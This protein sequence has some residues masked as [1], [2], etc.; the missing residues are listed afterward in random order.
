[1]TDE[2]DTCCREGDEGKMQAATHGAL[3]IPTGF[4]P[5]DYDV[6]EL[7]KFKRLSF[8][9]TGDVIEGHNETG[10]LCDGGIR[11]KSKRHPLGGEVHGTGFYIHWQRGPVD[12]EHE[13]GHVHV[14]G[15]FVEDVLDAVYRR[16]AFYQNSPFA[17]DA[18][19]GAMSHIE[20]A[21]NLLLSRREDRK[22]RGV[23]GKN[24]K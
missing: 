17:C 14:N 23:Q 2:K 24:I 6:V 20:E 12:R 10:I 9:D 13:S 11:N 21:L 5:L 1:M 8:A 15:A 19:E 18:N 4:V 22:N 16:L 3:P 7:Q